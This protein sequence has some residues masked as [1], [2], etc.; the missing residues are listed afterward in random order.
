MM[1]LVVVVVL[2]VLLVF[3]STELHNKC[4]S[5]SVTT[6]SHSLIPLLT[7]QFGQTPL[8]KA[9]DYVDALNALLDRGA[10]IEATDNVR[11][12]FMFWAWA[13]KRMDHRI[14]NPGP[15]CML[16]PDVVPPIK[17]V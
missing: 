14:P 17:C 15:K 12:P 5:N 4:C 2:V 9:L 11:T 1:V 16:I 6:D 8:Y 3:L 7:P 13:R 10:N